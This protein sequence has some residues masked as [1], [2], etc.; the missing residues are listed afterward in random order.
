MDSIYYIL[1]FVAVYGLVVSVLFIATD[2][3]LKKKI[4]ENNELQLSN[5]QLKTQISYYKKKHLSSVGFDSVFNF[6]HT[7]NPEKYVSSEYV[8]S[9]EQKYGI[10]FPEVLRTYYIKHNCAEMEETPFVMHNIEFCV[11]FI[12]PL[13]YGTVSV[14]SLL[15]NWKEEVEFKDLVPLAQD[16]DGDNYWWNS[17]TNQVFYISI[18]NA[19]N[20]ILITNS[21]EDFFEMLN[22]CY[23]NI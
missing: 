4:T 8:N 18:G 6:L 20:P 5:K 9:V 12:N 2:K 1:F 22:A 14:E 19:E 11:E 13:K 7:E 21:V 23:E 17:K 3:M 16:V 10:N 15:D